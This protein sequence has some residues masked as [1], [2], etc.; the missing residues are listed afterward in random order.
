MVNGRD[1][2]GTA[3]SVAANSNL[4]SELDHHYETSGLVQA[5]VERVF[6]HADDHARLSSH[7]SKSSWMMGGG[8]MRLEFDAGRANRRLQ[9]SAGRQDFG[10]HACRRR[11]RNGTKSAKGESMADDR[12][13][14]NS[15][16]WP[17]SDGLRG[18]AT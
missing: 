9:D 15:S 8:S 12:H 10:H 1:L 14:Q 17:L 6:A 4:M 3:L 16:D 2:S 5:P 18:H 11:D 7:M 13:A